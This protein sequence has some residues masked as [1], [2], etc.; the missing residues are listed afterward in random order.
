MLFA[1]IG[2]SDLAHEAERGGGPF[3]AIDVA[4]VNDIGY[5]CV[6]MLPHAD[7]DPVTYLKL[8]AAR[9][10]RNI[11]QEELRGATCG[12][13]A[14]A[15]YH[16]QFA[17]GATATEF[18]LWLAPSLQTP[19]SDAFVATVTSALA[20]ADVRARTKGD[21]LFAIG[22]SLVDQGPLGSSFA[23]V[24]GNRQLLFHTRQLSAETC[25]VIY[26]L[27]VDSKLYIETSQA[28]LMTLRAPGVS[29]QPVDRHDMVIDVTSAND[30]CDVLR[31]G[32]GEWKSYAAERPIDMSDMD[33][34]NSSIS[35]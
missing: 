24:A 11:E 5:L 31:R 10:P 19:N 8:I 9:L 26:R 22:R 29:G 7:V 27:A 34:T 20:A 13:A 1:V 21:P 15:R 30:L 17:A 23:V 6:T 25:N 28:D 12:E 32:F 2:A 4:S 16:V 14:E 33:G 18:S 3:S 35:D